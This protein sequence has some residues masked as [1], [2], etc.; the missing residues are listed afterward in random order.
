M[1]FLFLHLFSKAE[2]SG[3]YKLA[4]NLLQWW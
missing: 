1:P 2:L 3:T 4:Q